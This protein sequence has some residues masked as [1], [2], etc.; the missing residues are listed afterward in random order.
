[1]IRSSQ[2]QNDMPE[3]SVLLCVYNGESYLAACLDSI[4]GQTFTD[5]EF[6]IVNDG[7]TDRSFEILSDYAQKDPRILLVDQPENKGIAASVTEGLKYCHGKYIARMDQ[8][9]I[10]LPDRFLKQHQ[11]LES[12]PNI[13]VLGSSLAFIDKDG[14]LT[15]EKLIRPTDPLVIRLQMYYQCVVH[16]P[17]VLMR[18]EYYKKYNQDSLEKDYLAA[19]DYS[20]WL[21]ENT[22]HLYANLEEPCLLY[23]I[24]QH[25]TSKEKISSQMKETL[26]SAQLAYQQLLGQSIPVEVINSFYYISRVTYSDPLIINKGLVTIY[27]IQK[28]FEK[29]NTLNRMQKRVTRRF[30]Y[31]KLKSYMIKYR[32]IPGVMSRGI[33]FLI[34]LSTVDILI[35]S[36][37][38]IFGHKQHKDLVIDEE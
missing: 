30:S 12:H 24:H 8:D 29:T 22:R 35:D 23:R 1:M 17:S 7:S 4:L 37:N 38:K 27:Q 21:R 19:D 34:R 2:A 3:I 16:N 9:D 36:I 31:E 26:H 5:F 25:Q 14:N 10:S 15:G 11:Y 6:V 28:A 13:D 20:L 32:S 18:S 33:L